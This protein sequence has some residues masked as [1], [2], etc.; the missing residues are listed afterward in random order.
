LTVVRGTACGRSD[1]I[2][3]FTDLD[4]WRKAH[5]LFVDLCSDLKAERAD[6]AQRAIGPQLLRCTGSISANIAE[7][8]NRSKKQFVNALDIALGEANETESWLYKLRDAKL[9]DPEVVADRLRTTVQVQRMLTSLKRRIAENPNAVR[10]SP[11]EYEVGR[12]IEPFTS[13]EE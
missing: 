9:L 2:R 12:P 5:R 4:V 6:V 8:F 13:I 3:R 11:A 1:G 10:E 7:G